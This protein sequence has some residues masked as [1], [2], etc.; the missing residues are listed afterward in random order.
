MASTESPVDNLGQWRAKGSALA[1]QG[2][3]IVPIAPGTKAPNVR[4]WQKI[5]FSRS[6]ID[7]T[8]RHHGV[9][10]KGAKTPGVDLDIADETICRQMVDWCRAN[11]GAAPVRIGRP[12]RALMVYRSRTPFR[13]SRSDAY[14]SPDGQTHQ[15][16]LIGDGG[17]F[18]AYAIHPDTNLPYAWPERELTEVSSRDL[19]EIS[20]YHVDALYEQFGKIVTQAGWTRVEPIQRSRNSTQIRQRQTTHELTAPVHDLKAAMS[21]IPIQPETYERWVKIGMALYHA[22]QG[23]AEGFGLWDAWS[24]KG[25]QY[26]SSKMEGKW[27]S[28]RNAPPGAVLGSRTIFAEADKYDPK[29]RNR[30]ERPNAAELGAKLIDLGTIGNHS[31]IA[32]VSDGD[33]AAAGQ[34]PAV[35]N[36]DVDYN[37]S[38][39]ALITSAKFDVVSLASFAGQDVPERRWIVNDL[40]PANNVADLSGDGGTGKSLLALQ[41]A[42]SVA[43]GRS[44]LGLGVE[45]GAVLYLSCEDGI[46][47]IR[48]RVAPILTSMGLE[49]ADLIDLT[50]ADLTVAEGTELADATTG[51]LAMTALYANLVD[52]IAKA[53]PKLVIVDT[54]ADAFGGSEIDRIQVRTFVRNLRKLC[55]EH[56]LSVLMLS[57]PSVGGMNS[58]S[59]QSGS[60]A[61]GN[62]VRSRLYLER[63]RSSDGTVLDPDLRTL[64]VKKNNYGASEM[65][66]M[67]RWRGGLFQTDGLLSQSHIDRETQNQMVEGEFLR[68]LEQL[69]LEGQ[70]VGISKSSNYAPAIFAK[71]IDAE[72]NTAGKSAK[73]G[74]ISSRAFAEA[75]ERLFAKRMIKLVEDGPPSRRR[76]WLAKTG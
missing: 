39:A 60:T 35:D 65:E 5:D 44:W 61:W 67:L 66:I 64:K 40:I 3:D 48:R 57:H 76:K 15:I 1:R 34:F 74:R 53:M 26:N 41:L 43:T 75:M 68:L 28:F 10:V 59:G 18:V 23:S 4:N 49:E 55:I 21:A 20:Q 62:S 73:I 22:T 69:R 6:N 52:H 17:Q 58:G 47:E 24:V 19:G 37:R 38:H 46:D 9:G 31:E 72:N 32:P 11:I 14:R 36:H 8:Y 42:A 12:P 2:Y 45:R 50:V 30:V 13:K 16:E 70:H 29:W 54:R 33:Q 7:R 63:S 71:R 51:K 27:L 56:D 25:D